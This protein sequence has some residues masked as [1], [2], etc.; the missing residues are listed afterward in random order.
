M[1]KKVA[2]MIAVM[3]AL[4]PL[5]AAQA[6]APASEVEQAM[7]ARSFSE[8]LQAIPMLRLY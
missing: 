3:G 5:A 1:D 4:A 7:Q 2:G 8:L 6:A